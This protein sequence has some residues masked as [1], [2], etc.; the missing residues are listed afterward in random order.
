MKKLFA[1]FV[2]LALAVILIPGLNPAKAEIP[3]SGV[4]GGLGEK[5][6]T[7][8]DDVTVTPNGN[9]TQTVPGNITIMVNG[10]AVTS[11]VTPCIQNDRVMVPYRFIAEAL[12]STVTW[13]EATK[14]VTAV[15]E[16]STV[17]LY[18]GQ[19]CIMVN[20]AQKAIDVAPV[21]KD[22]RTMI[23]LRAFSEA[24]G[25]E[26][27]WDGSTQTANITGHNPAGTKKVFKIK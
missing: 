25:Y 10:K 23:P 8:L 18:V 6:G 27:E 2:V 9:P 20:G 3:S 1:F 15:K 26:V 4:D 5:T 14:K 22:G 16:T 24:L 21:I 7:N 19:G 11:D 12:G 17:E 13:D